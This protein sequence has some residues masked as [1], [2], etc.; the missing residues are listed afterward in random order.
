MLKRSLALAA[1]V[2]LALP[3]AS[4]AAAAAAAAPQPDPNAFAKAAAA[5]GLTCALGPQS[6]V[7]RQDTADAWIVEIRCDGGVD[8]GRIGV[9]P[10][11][12]GDQPMVYN[13][14]KAK[15]AGLSCVI[16]KE[17]VAFP[18]LT[19]DIKKFDYSSLCKVAESRLM[20]LS[21]N[22]KTVYLEVRCDDTNLPGEVLQYD[23]ATLKPTVLVSCDDAQELGGGCRIAGAVKN[24]RAIAGNGMT[25]AM[26]N[27]TAS[28]VSG[29][30]TPLTQSR[31]LVPFPVP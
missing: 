31:G 17:S 8:D 30:A 15:L 12:A 9:F 23:A 16:T 7:L 3:S 24:Q 25:A 26:G 10:K 4:F 20:G 19:A 29:G 1:A 13:C 11:K 6:L 14:A 27:G 22:R 5:D 2:C 21:P 28:N 18:S